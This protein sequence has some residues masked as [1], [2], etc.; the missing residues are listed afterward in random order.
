M[1]FIVAIFIVS[2]IILGC[3]SH[4][5]SYFSIDGYY[6][7]NTGYLDILYIQGKE[8]CHIYSYNDDEIVVETGKA[9]IFI[10]SAGE[11]AILSNYFIFHGCINPHVANNR[12]TIFLN[13]DNDR[14]LIDIDCGLFYKKSQNP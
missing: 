7:A 8:Y 2:I 10:D 14:L 5:R 12:D 6:F 13:I 9:S 11:Y 1:R 3:S 4:R